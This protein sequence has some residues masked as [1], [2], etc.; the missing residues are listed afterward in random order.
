M[1][2]SLNP[3]HHLH[4][5]Y[6]IAIRQQWLTPGVSNCMVFNLKKGTNVIKKMN[7]SNKYLHLNSMQ[8]YKR[9]TS[10]IQNAQLV[11]II[12]RLNNPYGAWMRLA[13]GP[14]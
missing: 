4:R 7:Y 6:T 5:P 12:W 2:Q 13:G 11:E 9:P 10:K 14:G 1:N 8:P 3:V